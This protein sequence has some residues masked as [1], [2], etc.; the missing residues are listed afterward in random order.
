ME[1]F[2]RLAEA[3]RR[4]IPIFYDNEMIG[5]GRQFRVDGSNLRTQP[6]L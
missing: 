4:K 1:W 3:G 2:A 6:H 5:F